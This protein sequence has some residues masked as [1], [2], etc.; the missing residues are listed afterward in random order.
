MA[1]EVDFKYEHEQIY[2]THTIHTDLRHGSETIRHYSKNYITLFHGLIS[3]Y[4]LSHNTF[5][6]VYTILRDQV[7]AEVTYILYIL[8]PQ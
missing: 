6:W 3:L 8:H 5:K 7:L 1:R 2:E 4:S